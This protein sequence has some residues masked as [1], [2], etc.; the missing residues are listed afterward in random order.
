MALMVTKAESWEELGFEEP[1]NKKRCVW[2]TGVEE[3]EYWK[4]PHR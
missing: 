4:I 1:L 2:W 3:S